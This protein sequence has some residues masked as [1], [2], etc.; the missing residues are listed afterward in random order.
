ML[1]TNEWDNDYCPS[2]RTDLEDCYFG[3][4]LVVR[5]YDKNKD[6]NAEDSCLFRGYIDNNDLL[7]YWDRYDYTTEISEGK[8]YKSITSKIY[9]RMQED[10]RANGF[11]YFN[12][13]LNRSKRMEFNNTTFMQTYKIIKGISVEDLQEYSIF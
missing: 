12:Y 13:G 2:V 9:Q 3:D 4:S 11:V 7:E 1:I 6:L 5:I 8:F 10:T